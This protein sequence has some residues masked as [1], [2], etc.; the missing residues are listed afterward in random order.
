MAY[1]ASFKPMERLGRDGWRAMDAPEPE[2]PVVDRPLPTRTPRR[3]LV[4]A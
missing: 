4:D 3:I 1:K 2:E